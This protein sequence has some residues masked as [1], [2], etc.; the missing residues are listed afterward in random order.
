MNILNTNEV[1]ILNT[2]EL[3]TEYSGL[4]R[5]WNCIL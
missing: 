4:G 3:N 5:I 2:T 1:N